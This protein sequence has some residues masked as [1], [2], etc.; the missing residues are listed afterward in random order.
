[1]VLTLKRWK[2]RSSPGI[3]AGAW[4]AHISSQIK[5]P[6]TV[7]GLRSTRSPP[8]TSGPRSSR[9]RPCLCLA[10]FASFPGHRARRQA[11]TTPGAG[12]S[13]PVA[14]QAHNLKVAGSNPAPATTDVDLVMPPFG[15]AL[16]FVGQAIQFQSDI[17]GKAPL[18][19]SRA[20]CM[21]RNQP[22][23]HPW[24]AWRFAR[25]RWSWASLSAQPLVMTSRM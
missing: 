12:W 19:W 16:S 25:H 7:K 21:R 5:N 11:Q 9:P 1:M 14:R 2:S 22:G 3:E 18:D 20:A 6:S 17:G 4:F 13:S 10:R 15:A 23:V 24:R 8:H